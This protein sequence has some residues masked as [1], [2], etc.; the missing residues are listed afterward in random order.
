MTQHERIIA[1]I[2]RF[3]SISSME[4][5]RD[6]GITKLS[7]RISELKAQGIEFEQQYEEG[8]NRFG[9]DIRFMRYWLSEEECQKKNTT[10]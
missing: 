7:T 10:G 8:R 6:L 4:A 9:E 3:G 1:Y 2:K 5:F